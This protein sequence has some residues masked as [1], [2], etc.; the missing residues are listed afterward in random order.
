LRAFFGG[1]AGRSVASKDA[2]LAVTYLGSHT[3]T[4]CWTQGLEGAH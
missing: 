3:G 4:Y 2:D 1:R